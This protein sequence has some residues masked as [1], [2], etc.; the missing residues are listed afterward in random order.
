[1]STEANYGNNEEKEERFTNT[2]CE[3]RWREIVS[4]EANYGNNEEKEE[5]FTTMRVYVAAHTTPH[6]FTRMGAWC[7]VGGDLVIVPTS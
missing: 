4:T 1:V 3:S 7:S 6:R 5:R 2:E